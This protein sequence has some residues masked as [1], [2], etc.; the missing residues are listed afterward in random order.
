MAIL[1]SAI[2]AVIGFIITLV[3]VAL[4]LSYIKER[5]EDT[6]RKS[7]VS[8]TEKNAFQSYRTNNSKEDTLLS[9][10]KT[11]STSS[12]LYEAN[13]N[14][15]V[16]STFDECNHYDSSSTKNHNNDSI[17][18][19]NSFDSGSSYDSSSSGGFD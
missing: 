4:T 16:S 19:G 3:G 13:A 10:T 17:N 12:L 18:H 9:P 14:N 6:K 7:K 5:R 1:T 11:L 2:I 15:Q 8:T